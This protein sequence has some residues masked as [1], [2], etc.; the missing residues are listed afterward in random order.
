MKDIKINTTGKP[1]VEIITHA[2]NIGYSMDR[3]HEP[4]LIK[5]DY[6]LLSGYKDMRWC[7]EEIF[8]S[9]MSE[10]MSYEDFM[11]YGRS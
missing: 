2:L 3:K 4:N 7:T 5:A 1:N 6:I 11:E 8:N 10:E 9:D